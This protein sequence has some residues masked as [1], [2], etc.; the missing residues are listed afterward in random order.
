MKNLTT[1]IH[2]DRRREAKNGYPVKL[3]V[4]YYRQPRYFDT[5][6][7]LTAKE[8]QRLSELNP[9]GM[10]KE[11]KVKLNVC[12]KK[13]AKIIEDLGEQFS[14]EK[15]KELYFSKSKQTDLIAVFTGYINEL[16]E[17]GRAGTAIS[18]QNARNSLATY[19]GKGKKKAFVGITPGWLEKYQKSMELKGKSLTTI[20]IYTRS[21]RTIFNIAIDGGIISSKN[22]PFGKRRY[23]IPAG[24]STKK[25]LNKLELK[26]IFDYKP[27]AGTWEEIA[28]D[29]WI[30][31][32]LCNGANIKDICR[33]RNKNLNEKTI[34]FVRAK[35]ERTGIKNQKNIVASRT[36]HINEIIK[37]QETRSLIPEQHVFPF[38]DGSESPQRE[39]AKIGRVTKDINKW[40]GQIGKNL[41]IESKITT[42]TARHSFATMLK[43]GGAPTEFISESLGHMDLK[44]T[45]N[46]LDSFEDETKEKY[47]KTLTDFG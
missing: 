38:L 35:T 40:M 1:G 37:R 9:R 21:L 46:Y 16:N 36:P 13:A 32:Y 20:G 31:S 26:L 27:E 43:W 17:K 24:Q 11:V 19:I 41:G 39:H 3:R 33:L 28:H 4:T 47:A 6:Q 25:A 7:R 15:F 8:F 18:Y 29:I 44:T 30:F 34:T 2:L 22:Y 45:E 12:E 23:Q 14:F 42:Y 10:L 5:G